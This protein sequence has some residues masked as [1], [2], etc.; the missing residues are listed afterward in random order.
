MYSYKTVLIFF[1]IAYITTIGNAQEKNNRYLI[2]VSKAAHT[3]SIVNPDTF[4]VIATIPAGPN[5][6]EVVVSDD[7]RMAYISNPGNSDLHEI[8][9]IDLVHKKALPSISTLPFLGPHGLALHHNKLWFTA[10]G[11]KAVARYNLN[12]KTIDW[13]MGTGQ[14]VT[15]LIYV[16]KSDKEFYTTNVQSG[17]ISLFEHKLLQP[18]LPPTGKLP[19]NAKPHWDW[20]QSLIHADKGV[21]GFDV[22]KDEKELWAVAPSGQ[23]TIIDLV[24]HTLKKQWNTNIK[25]AHRLKFTPD[26]KYVV[27][28]SVA[29]GAIVKFN[30]KTYK[31]M[32]EVTIAQ[33]GEMLMDDLQ[34]R[35]FISCPLVGYIAVVDLNKMKETHRF[36]VGNR[37]DGMAWSKQ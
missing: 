2:A 32:A 14:D 28:V 30:A 23:I 8:N 17:T 34:N 35:L 7:G 4:K 22:A 15:H 11:S 6:H 26:G 36:K 24:S 5:T 10:Q 12:D 33:G 18:I 20:V 27:V 21:E 9:V 1:I 19:P 3:L 25:G 13:A 31:K 16:K 37:P 29:T